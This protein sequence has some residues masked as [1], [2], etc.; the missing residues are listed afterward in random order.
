M[1]KWTI[2]AIVYLL[3][4]IGGYN[5]Y[6]AVADDQPA[7]NESAHNTA[8]NEHGTD[9]QDEAQGGETDS[10]V[11]EG[12]NE[13]TNNNEDDHGD[14]HSESGNS[15]V[16]TEIEVNN[17]EITI[18]IKDKNGEPV[19]ELEVNHE[20]LLHLIIVDD[21]LDQYYHLHPDQVSPGIFTVNHELEDGSYKAFI[22]IKP[23]N[24]S[25]HVSPLAFTI[26]EVDS[27]GHGTLQADT[28]YIKTVDG[29]TTTLSPSSLKTGE[30]VTLEF[31]V[32]TENLEPYLGAMGHVVILDEQANE[33]LHVHPASESATIFETEFANPGM[34]KIWAEFKVD[35]KVI[36]YPYV[37]K[38]VE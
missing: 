24:A 38:I 6:A 10:H 2:S 34:Y 14:N 37:L 13:E 27:H 25:Y 22:D 12:T 5:I 33:Y 21:H 26:G 1:K 16:A 20:K 29:V 9:K 11:H 4:V 23:K 19:E 3:V 36:V 31:D 18:E 17:G 28:N 32:E 15:D 30:H 8:E 7:E 35:G